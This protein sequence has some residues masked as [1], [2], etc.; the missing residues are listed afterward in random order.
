MMKGPSIK[1]LGLQM[2]DEKCIFQTMAFVVGHDLLT[3]EI[4]PAA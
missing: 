3:M 2:I 4:S 1:T